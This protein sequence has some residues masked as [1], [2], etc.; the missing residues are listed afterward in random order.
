YQQSNGVED[1][2]IEELPLQGGEPKIIFRQPERISELAVLPESR[3]LLATAVDPVSNLQQVFHI[4]LS[5][6]TKT[7]VTNDVFFYFGV[8]VDRS[9]HSIVASQRADEQRV[10]IGS[11]RD[12]T[13]VKPLNQDQNAYRNV[14]WTPDGRIVYDGYE[15]NVNHIWIVDA[16][17]RNLQ[18]LTT[19][20]SDDVNPKISPDGRYIVFV[21]KRTGRSQIWRMNIDGSDQVLLADVSGTSGYPKFGPDGQSVVFEWSRDGKRSLVNVPLAGGQITEIDGLDS[22]PVNNS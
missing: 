20:E 3:G 13:G 16:D 11:A 4:S 6:G 5:D 21:S 7:R 10:W 18:R 22:I 8:S 15:N 19:S 2:T 17:G 1:Y 9:G 14:E 12:L